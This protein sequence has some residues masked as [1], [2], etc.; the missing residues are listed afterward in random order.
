MLPQN[1]VALPR[2][3]SVLAFAGSTFDAYP[4]MLQFR[5]WIEIHPGARNRSLDINT[6]KKRMRIVFNDMRLFIDDLPPGQKRPDPAD[7]ELIFG[8]W[9]WR[10]LSFKL[11]RFHFKKNADAFD[12]EPVGSGLKVGKGH[13][14]IFAGTRPAIEAAR[15]RIY[16]KLDEAGRLH[17]RY[18]NMEPFEVLRDIIRE[19]KFDDVGGPPQLV[20]IYQSGNTQPFAV[21]W[22]MGNDREIT[23]LGRPLFPGETHRLPV[24]DPDR[25]NFLPQENAA[26]NGQSLS[27]DKSLIALSGIP[28]SALN[29]L[30]MTFPNRI[31]VVRL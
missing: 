5:N 15:D 13:P 31:N 2:S 10:S 14:I 20:K 8:G 6:L 26:K 29:L 22:P 4:L 3:D 11:W 16:A 17:T 28:R 27:E 24:I 23:V 9:S 1:T 21:R 25:I 18:F 12:F 7:C 19:A 30:A